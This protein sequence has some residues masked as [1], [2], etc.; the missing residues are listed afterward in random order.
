[1]NK[2]FMFFGMVM[3][4]LLTTIH[5]LAQTAGVEG[6]VGDISLAGYSL[7]VILTVILG[8]IYKIIPSVPDR[9]K[10]L[11]AIIIGVG[12]GLIA[13]CYQGRVLDF[14]TVIDGI[15]SGLMTGAAA[16]GLYEASMKTVGKAK[17]IKTDVQ[18]DA[19]TDAQTLTEA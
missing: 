7:P 11:I 18:T 17:G 5:V 14:K 10:A 15:L 6:V 12:I 3:V 2:L 9:F 8:I 1:M 19:Q 16:V 4:L 13:M